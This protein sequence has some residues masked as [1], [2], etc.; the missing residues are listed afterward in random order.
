MTTEPRTVSESDPV[1]EPEASER[2]ADQPL[3]AQVLGAFLG[4]S[5]ATS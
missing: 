3:A 4:I 5:A 2:P 1:V